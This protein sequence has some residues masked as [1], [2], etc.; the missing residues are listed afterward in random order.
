MCM[1]VDVHIYIYIY[2]YILHT[3]PRPCIPE[4][5]KL[6]SCC[7]HRSY[8]CVCVC[9]NMYVYTCIC[10]ISAY[11]HYTHHRG[12]VSRN[13]TSCN[14]ATGIDHVYTYTYTYIYTY[15]Y[16]YIMYVS[17]YTSTA[18]YPGTTEAAIWLQV[19]VITMREI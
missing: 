16:M 10:A 4:L 7:R 6:Q 8:V 12:L 18:L 1:Y 19:Y 17:V 9:V 5:Q 2:I 11:T 13:Y 14:L 3:P 15:I